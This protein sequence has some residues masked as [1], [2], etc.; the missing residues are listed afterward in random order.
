VLEHVS[1]DD[2]LFG[3]AAVA[4]DGSESPIAYPGDAGNFI[5]NPPFPS[6]QPRP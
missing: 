3:V 6:P 2:W 1:I 5:S 4:A